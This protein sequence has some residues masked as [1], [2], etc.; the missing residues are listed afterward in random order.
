MKI[1]H[2]LIGM[3]ALSAAVACT[4]DLPPVTPSLEVDKTDISVAAAASEATFNVTSN[5][6]W[7]A[8]ADA[9]WVTVNPASGDASDEAVGVTVEVEANTSEEARTANV[10]VKAGDLSATV[11]V[12]QAGVTGTDPEPEPEPEPDVDTNSW[13][14]MGMFV[15]NSWASDIPMTKDGEWIVA[16]GAQFSEL[17]FK[18]RANASWDDATNIGVA[19]GSERGVVNGKITVVTA[20]YSKANHGADAAD[21]KL[22]GVAG[23]YDVYFSFENLEVYVMEQGYKPGEKEPQ[24]PEPVEVTYT[25]VG[26]IQDHPWVNNYEGGL[27]VAEGNYLVAK[28]VQLVWNSTCYGGDYNVIEFKIVETGTWDGYAY[29][30]KNV[31]QKANTEISLTAGGENIALEAPEG[32]YDVYFDKTNAK[33]WVMTPGYEPGETPAVD[34]WETAETYLL[35]ESASSSR[36]VLR[37]MKYYADANSVNVRL[38]ASA[39]KITETATNYVTIMIYDTVTGTSGAGFYGWWNDAKGNTEF[40]AEHC[41][42]VSG[43]DLTLNIGGTDVAVENTEE[44]DVVT[45][46]FAIPRSVS[47]VLKNSEAYVGILAMK[48]WD[49]TGAMPDK[50]ADMLK[51]TLP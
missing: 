49:A 15:D 16:K 10:T 28:N 42:V 38:T 25:V 4:E 46:T 2:F 5:Q 18:I 32:A 6:A 19:P 29:P 20:E 39:A 26:T 12:S 11:K 23:T 40:A 47:D 45:W 43:T 1:K 51:V 48:D 3:L 17:I 50:Y 22:N 34:P 44:G 41:G 30:E 21:I 7:T 9:A 33:V 36:Q 8:T 13:G 24:T 37:E 27:M 35:P 14:M 31:M